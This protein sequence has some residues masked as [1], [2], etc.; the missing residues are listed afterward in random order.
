[1]L[2]LILITFGKMLF[3]STVSSLYL[4]HPVCTCKIS[5]LQGVLFSPVNL[6][7]FI[8][9]TK[10]IAHSDVTIHCYRVAQSYEK[11]VKS[12]AV[13]QRK[14]C[15]LV[16]LLENVNL[17]VVMQLLLLLQ[18]IIMWYM[19]LVSF[20]RQYQDWTQNLQLCIVRKLEGRTMNAA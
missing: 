3:I 7:V 19:K 1:M 8:Q 20:Y 14:Y 13:F 11:W 4:P 16:V 10:F 15:Q 6:E 2:K 17:L 18:L 12:D 5:S 9:L